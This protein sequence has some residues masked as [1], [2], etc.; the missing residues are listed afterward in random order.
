ML[1]PLLEKRNEKENSESITNFNN[2][3]YFNK[4]QNITHAL[5]KKED[6]A[7]KYQGD[8][9]KEKFIFSSI[10]YCK[11]FVKFFDMI[12]NVIK[13]DRFLNNFSIHSSISNSPNDL[14]NKKS[15]RMEE[16]KPLRASSIR[17]KKEQ[18]KSKIS[19]LG[20]PEFS[21]ILRDYIKT[22]ENSLSLL[23]EDIESFNFDKYQIKVIKERFSPLYKDKILNEINT[24]KLF[25]ILFL[26]PFIS[27]NN[28]IQNR[29]VNSL[30]EDFK[31]MRKKKL[32]E[33]LIR[34]ST[35]N[36]ENDLNT[37]QKERTINNQTHLNYRE[38][39][40]NLIS[41]KVT[42]I[43]KIRYYLQ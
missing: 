12:N 9:F 29:Q 25:E 14:R 5:K 10:Y 15:E 18:K 30:S 22:L 19:D 13:D 33:W 36:H 24:L 4:N 21:R 3:F 40:I 2:S 39:L 17:R 8:N 20:V 35:Q 26:N 37:L 31:Q 23:E 16:E 6:D 27:K 34:D 42:L 38:I 41:G 1:K 28:E 7:T 43:H 32:V 11:S